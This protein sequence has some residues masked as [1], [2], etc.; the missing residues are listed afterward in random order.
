MLSFVVH[1]ENV[2]ITNDEETYAKNRYKQYIEVSK[3]EF[4]QCRTVK[5]LK[6]KH[7]DLLYIMYTDNKTFLV[8]FLLLLENRD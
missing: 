6:C 8:R 1:F 2:S 7:T 3:F 4:N 5:I